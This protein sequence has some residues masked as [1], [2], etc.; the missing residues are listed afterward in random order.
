METIP[1]NIA[2]SQLDQLNI[3]IFD[4]KT[5]SQLYKQNYINVGQ[6]KKQLTQI[7]QTVTS[8]I[9]TSTDLSLIGPV[10][11]SLINSSINNDKQITTMIQS[12]NKML[13]SR[14]NSGKIDQSSFDMSD[15]I[16][17]INTSNQSEVIKSA[18]KTLDQ[19]KKQ[20][21]K[22]LNKLH[23]MHIQ[24]T[25]NQFGEYEQIKGE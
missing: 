1:E 7:L 18:N 21:Q 20:K 11:T 19:I 24:S 16:S 9:K 25:T 14:K 23:Q 3:K 22:M 5:L 4:Q 13:I 2:T 15:I 12:I 6:F 8:L 17:Q 10:L